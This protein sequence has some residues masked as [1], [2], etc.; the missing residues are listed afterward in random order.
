MLMYTVIS[1]ILAMSDRDE[2][3]LASQM[4]FLKNVDTD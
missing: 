4:N 2:N 3:R 1:R